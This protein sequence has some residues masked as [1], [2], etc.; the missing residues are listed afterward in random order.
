MEEAMKIVRFSDPFAELSALHSQL[1]EMF[2]EAFG[3]TSTQMTNMPFMDVYN[4]DGNQLVAEI[5]APGFNKDDV[6]VSINQGMLEIKGEKKEKEEQKDKKRNYMVRESSESFY[7]RIALPKQADADNIA[8]EF[9]NGILKI[10][11]PFK[12]LPKPK[13]IKISAKN[14]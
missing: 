1:D 13:Q 4:E 14:K 7:R 6:S 9:D 11:V 12:E 5:H 8:A 2:N 3:Q 10:S